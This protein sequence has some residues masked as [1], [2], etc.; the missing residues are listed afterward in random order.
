ME[1]IMDI[2]F[3][4][5]GYSVIVV[6]AIMEIIVKLISLVVLIPLLLIFMVVCP[7]FNMEE[8]PEFFQKWG[9]YMSENYLRSARF[10]KKYYFG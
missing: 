3:K 8:A 7:I 4:V 6:V 9:S 5:L 1:T 2:I 10:L